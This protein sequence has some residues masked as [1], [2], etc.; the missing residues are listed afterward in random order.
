MPE[1]PPTAASGPRATL[2]LLDL[3]VGVPAVWGC[4]H[5]LVLK[6]MALA[7][8][9]SL[10]V[11]AT[12]A[13]ALTAGCGWA[14]RRWLVA[15]ERPRPGLLLAVLA[16]PATM[17][18]LIRWPFSGV[19]F[20]PVTFSVDVAHHGGLVAWIADHD[21]LPRSFQP[22]LGGQSRYPAGAH[23]VA[24][25][26]SRLTG[27]A[28]V[29]A[30]WLVAVAWVVLLWWTSSAIAVRLGR[31][32]ALAW[33]AVPVVIGLAGW[34]YTIG[35]VGYDFFF[36]QLGGMWLGWGTVAVIVALRPAPLPAWVVPAFGVVGTVACLLTYPQ[37]APVPAMAVAADALAGR[38]GSTSWRLRLAGA[39]AVAAMGVAALLVARG[40]DID[41]SVIAGAGEG[42]RA[43]LTLASIGGLI[44]A[45]VL[46]AGLAE[47]TGAA[48]A[49]R[50]G[51]A[52][53]LGAVAAPALLAVG[54]AALRLPVF[55]SVPVVSYRIA[56]NA[57]TAAPGL[58]IGATL[59]VATAVEALLRA[60]KSTPERRGLR[61]GLGGAAALLALGAIQAPVQRTLLER[62]ALSRDEQA[63]AAWAHDN[64]DPSE[65]G[66]SMRALDGYHA[67]WIALRRPTGEAASGWGAPL[68]LTRWDTWP[69][70]VPERYLVA[71]GF[72]A[73]R[74]MG[75]EGVTVLHRSGDAVVLE[76]AS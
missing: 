24:A 2:S 20:A 44:V 3:A 9:S 47:L 17:V 74:A 53:A 70:N 38:L 37:A 42:E 62:P 4:W 13:L 52:A 19:L 16:A 26:V 46:V 40:M 5:V 36:A 57:Y 12:V 65:V 39:A 67:W 60:L 71:S 28:P 63:A 66:V 34:R 10:V 27:Q 41:L 55:G 43:P 59:A 32:R 49:K 22:E 68:R 1:A 15:L 11:A 50:P 75:R 51:A 48:W 69:Q 35:M 29:T 7:G 54:M 73:E 45:V 56:K 14:L 8:A 6:A 76:R 30:M 61:A 23:G 33:V 18:A 31:S 25:F 21:G 72:L 64:L 58:L